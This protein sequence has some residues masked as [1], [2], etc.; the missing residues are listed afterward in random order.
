MPFSLVDAPIDLLTELR[1]ASGDGRAA[2]SSKLGLRRLT[3]GMQNATYLW[4]PPDGRAATVIKIYSRTDRRRVEREW[5]ALTL[6]APH[7]LGTVPAPL[8]HDPAPEHPA[9]GMTVL[10]GEPLLNGPDPLAA[11]RALA[12]TT[13]R[14]HSV[15]LT[16]LLADLP[17][18]DSGEHYMVRLTQT[19]PE[20]LAGAPDDQLTPDMQRLLAQW[21]GSGDA[22]LVLES[23][24]RVLSH[25]DGN[26]LNWLRTDT[27]AACVDFEYAGYSTRPFDVADLIEH[28]S[29]RAVPDALR[30]QLLPDLGVTDA[31]RRRFAANQRTCAMRWLAVLWKQRVRRRDEFTAQHQ[32][33]RMLYN[34]DNPYARPQQWTA[35]DPRQLVIFP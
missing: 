21:Q 3:G 20:L 8:W 18:I 7:D 25:G 23:D 9:I 2:A 19:W 26:L 34:G 10:H 12:D 35:R 13:A 28:I 16:G 6:L 33:V 1:R 5:A 17:R 22:E 30:S 15:P 31:N 4:T 32:R 11:L 24:T 27:G 29:S 14:L